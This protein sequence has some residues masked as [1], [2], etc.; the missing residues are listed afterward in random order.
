MDVGFYV[1]LFLNMGKNQRKA[2]LIWR[3]RA[4]F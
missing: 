3:I 1:E 4:V 2:I